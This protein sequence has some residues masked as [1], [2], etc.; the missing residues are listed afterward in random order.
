MRGLALVL[1]LTAVLAPAA[2]R[3]GSGLIVGVSEDMMKWSAT[4]PALT[5][6]YA[7]R[8]NLGAVRV[9][10]RWSPGKIHVDGAAALAV[11]RA[12]RAAHGM[13]LVLAVYSRPDRAPVSSRAR[14]QYCVYVRNVLA[15]FREVRDVVIWNE[16][17]SGAFWRPQFGRWGTSAAPA[18]Y[19]RLLAHCWD[20]LHALD[21]DVNVIAA[22]APRGNDSPQAEQPSHS[23]VAFYREL[24]RV[25]RLSGRSAPILDTV[26]HNPYPLTSAEEPW[27]AHPGDGT[28]G[29]GDHDKLVAVL[30]EAFGRTAQPVPGTG[31]R[32]WYMEDGF[33][34]LVAPGKRGAYRGA[35]NDL[36]ASLAHDQSR[37][38]D[39]ALRL[40]YC[41][42]YVDAFFNFLLADEP[43]L[44][45]WQSGLLWADWKPKPSF[46][47]FKRSVSDVRRGAVDCGALRALARVSG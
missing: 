25:Y 39:T 16:P 31:L 3:A 28:I 20:V 26:G 41:Q 42:P 36:W 30:R 11:R 24:G 13:R 47:A 14:R 6:A 2:A 19:E 29:Q 10:L 22:S 7:R 18:A 33:Q 43:R 15:L 9:T 4:R 23:P 46:W 38:L 17:N 32:I 5:N 21:D 27:V 8:L 34:T 1:A 45:G 37:R 12:L 40:A 35:E 44:H